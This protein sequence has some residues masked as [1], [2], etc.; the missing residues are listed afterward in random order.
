LADRDLTNPRVIAVGTYFQQIGFLDNQRMLIWRTGL[1]GFGYS[2]IDTTLSTPVE[3]ALAEQVFFISSRL[4][5]HQILIG[6]RFSDQDQTGDLSLIDMD[7]GAERLL[8][9]GVSDAALR[10]EDGPDRVLDVAFLVRGRF[11]SAQDGLWFSKIPLP[12]Q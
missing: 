6:H 3:H 7:T 11:A 8:S 12:D 9:H 4:D 10:F 1:D 5:A 2:W